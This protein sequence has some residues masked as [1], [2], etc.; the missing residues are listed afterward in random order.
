MKLLFYF[1]FT[2]KNYYKLFG[3]DS[4]IGRYVPFFFGVLSIPILGI[5]SWQIKKNNSYLLTILLISVNIYLIN[6]SQETRYYSLVFLISIINLIFYYKILSLNL[7]GSKR[8][9]VFFLFIL[10]SVLSFSL[11][12]FILII[13]F[14]QIAYC[15]YAFY[16]FK[17]KNYLFFLS[18][19]IILIIYLHTKLRLPFV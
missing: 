14:S 7:V 8:I 6:Y 13:F 18:V 15:I 17:T 2:L 4:E 12:P 3:Y 16:V 9:Y 5:L 11:S 1:H 19:P 10:F